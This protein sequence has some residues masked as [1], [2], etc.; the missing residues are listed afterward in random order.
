M[1]WICNCHDG[2]EWPDAYDGV[3]REEQGMAQ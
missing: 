1:Q 2:R 3:V